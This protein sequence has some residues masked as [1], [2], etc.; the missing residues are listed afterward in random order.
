MKIV[1]TSYTNTNEYTDPEA[2]LQ[3]ISFYTGILEELAK[4][5]EVESIEQINYSAVLERKG[6]KYHFLNFKK[7]TLYF[8]WRVHNY[9]K[10]LKP[11]VVFVNGL[12]FPLQVI[13]LRLKLGKSVK[14]ILLHRGE[15]PYSGIKIFLQRLADKCINAY[16]FTSAEFG[17]EWTKYGNIS[18]QNKIY[19]VIQASSIFYPEEKA[20]AKSIG[21]INGE[22]VFLWVGRLGINK[23]PITVTKAFIQFLEF[24]PAAKLY[25]I[26]Q[27]Q[28]LLQE[29][30]GLTKTEP[31]AAKA[32]KFVGKVPHEQLQTWY[33]A[34]DFIISGSHHEGSGVAVSEAMSC[35]CVPVVTDI[36]SLRKMTGPGKC[37]L[38]YKRGNETALLKTLMQ[39]TEMDMEDERAK[40]LQQ[41][42][43]ELS[44]EAITKKI[45]Q[46]IASLQR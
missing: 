12:I 43:A 17:K 20:L 22:P 25:M 5:H 42:N 38:L 26:Y 13:Q 6:V 32:I 34:A 3:R 44:F 7:P 40:T 29:I 4:Q 15:K 39:T 11:D 14:I 21:G 30:K 10:K 8:P 18:S 28:E 41:F 45:E 23:D 24:E 33:N 19:E 35:G 9:I 2:W 31:K 37:G 1:S 16:L 27:S 46:V 36:I